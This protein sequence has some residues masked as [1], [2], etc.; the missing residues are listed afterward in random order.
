MYS[1]P[2]EMPVALKVPLK[3]I[4]VS[5]DER[6]ILSCELNKPNKPVK[7]YKNGKLLKDG[8]NCQ[9]FNDGCKY[10]LL[11]PKTNLSD[12]GNYTLKCDKIE[13]SATL[14]I[15]GENTV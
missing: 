11:L 1:I 8:M 6:V 3:N 12:A 4:S 13:T 10:S 7:W 14:V 15:K 9:I 5:E 2:L